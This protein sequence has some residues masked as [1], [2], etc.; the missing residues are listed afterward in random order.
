MNKI[1]QNK[2]TFLLILIAIV[3]TFSSFTILSLPV[4]F[5]Y[6]SKV[7][8]IEKNFYHNFKIFL[9]TSGNISYK[10]FPKPHL[11]VENASLNL[12]NT[13]DS[14]NLINTSDLKIFISL[15]NIYLRSFKNFNSAE[16]SDTNLEFKISDIVDLRNHMYKNIN[17][18]LSITNC[19]LFIRN[20]DDDVILISPIKKVIYK[21]NSKTKIKNLLIDGK[22]FGINFKSDWERNYKYPK[23]SIHN[24]N[25]FNPNI[26]IKNI[27]NFQSDNQFSGETYIEYFQDKL[28]Y[29]YEFFNN[30]IKIISPS[31][32][33]INF[34]IFSNIQLN[35]F[36][37][38]GSITIK[39]KKVET[40][41]DN[42]LLNLLVY[43]ENY[44]GNLTGIFKIKFSDLNNKL[45]QNGEI[46]LEINEKSISFN[47]S[48][49]YLNKIGTLQTNMKFIDREGETVFYSENELNIENHI[50]F[51]KVFQIG[52]KEAKNIKKI[53]FDLRKNVGETDIVISNIRINSSNNFK[54]PNQEFIVKNIQNLRANF[55]E[56]IN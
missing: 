16:I 22:I 25:L 47:N 46:D 13:N 38:N 48:V 41:I 34:K 44:L 54:K 32:K 23:K 56:V 2:I 11:L 29:N 51:A 12:K 33:N 10:P 15:Q 3:I 40:I 8:K 37:F 26:E 21:I 42:I 30:E 45:I 39:N 5:N 43:E 17:K 19:K 27:F 31:K 18:P 4:L 24:I 36:Y 1:K 6:E 52:S 28:E 35:P 9:K 50:E 20:T 55:R 53:F 49:F 7:T 14:S